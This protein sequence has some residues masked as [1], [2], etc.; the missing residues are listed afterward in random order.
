MQSYAWNNR[1]VFGQSE[2]VMFSIFDVGYEIKIDMFRWWVKHDLTQDVKHCN[3]HEIM[4]IWCHDDE[5][6]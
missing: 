1:V 5:Y 4:W 6:D 3:K 2:T